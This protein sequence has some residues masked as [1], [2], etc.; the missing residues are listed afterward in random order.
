M[1]Q[2]SVGMPGSGKYSKIVGGESD[3]D[4]TGHGANRQ[5][6]LS[7]A[8]KAG[9]WIQAASQGIKVISEATSGYGNNDQQPSGYGNNDPK[10]SEY[11]DNALQPPGYDNNA[12]LPDP[13]QMESVGEQPLSTDPS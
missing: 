8:E 6:G 5:S 4:F 11:G 1:P 9:H 13:G 2:K 3:I 7:T 12:Q 10:P